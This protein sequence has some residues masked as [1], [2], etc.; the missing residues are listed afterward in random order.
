MRAS[1]RV[2]DC[3]RACR[4]PNNALYDY[5]HTASVRSRSNT[6][7]PADGSSFDP[8]LTAMRLLGWSP[9]TATA[10]SSSVA[11]SRTSRKEGEQW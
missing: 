10:R 8:F 7:P 1:T 6:T 11:V 5:E 4:Y 3:D 9:Q 2:D